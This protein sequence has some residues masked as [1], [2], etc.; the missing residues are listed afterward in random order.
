[1]RLHWNNLPNFIKSYYRKGGSSSDI[2]AR[3]VKLSKSLL[4]PARER[5]QDVNRFL[6][7]VTQM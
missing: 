4:R 2:D 7:L 5:N 3:I 1:M 6:N